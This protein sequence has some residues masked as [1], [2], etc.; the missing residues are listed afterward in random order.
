MMK[1]YIDSNYPRPVLKILEDVHNLQKQKKYK[2]ER[3]E[4]N[5][6][7][8][9]DLKDSIFLVVDFQKKGISIPIIKQSEEGYKTIVCRVMDEKIDRFEFAM[10]VLRVWPHIIEKSD[11]N[12]KLFSF[13]YGGKK[14]RG[15]K[16]KNI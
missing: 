4:D 13:N 8:E 12:D 11:S 7:T 14:L 1:I 2:I 10:T 15:V 3:W 16:L 6:I 5:E 9:N